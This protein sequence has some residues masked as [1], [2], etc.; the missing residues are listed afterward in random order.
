MKVMSVV[1]YDSVI[2]SILMALQA[3]RASI[4][5]WNG[6]FYLDQQLGFI[7]R[8]ESTL[9]LLFPPDVSIGRY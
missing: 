6:L 3:E 2:S 4:S 7:V 9:K 1:S 8:E 5:A